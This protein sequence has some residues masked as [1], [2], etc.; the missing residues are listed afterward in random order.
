MLY[1]FVTI[2]RRCR[3][4]RLRYGTHDAGPKN[5]SVQNV[6]FHRLVRNCSIG[7]WMLKIGSSQPKLAY[8][9]ASR[10]PNPKRDAKELARLKM[11]QRA[12]RK[13]DSHHR[14]GYRDPKQD[15]Y[16][17]EQPAPLQEQVSAPHIE[18]S[19]EH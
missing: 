9:S 14:T 12:G 3:R 11:R 17:S 1:V 10:K 7:K 4:G 8:Q 6:A 19:A 13:E 15:R 2:M 16:R 5:E 18:V